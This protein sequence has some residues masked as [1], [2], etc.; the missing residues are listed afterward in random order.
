MDLELVPDNIR[1]LVDNRRL[2]DVVKLAMDLD[3]FSKIPDEMSLDELSLALDLDTQFVEYLMRVLCSSGFAEAIP[4]AGG[5]IVYRCTPVSSQ[6]LRQGSPLFIGQCVLESIETGKL[7]GG[8]VRN[9]PVTPSIDKTHWT[10]ER[11]RNIAGVA[12]LGGLQSAIASV[13]LAGHSRLLDI[14]GGHG[15]FSVFFTRKYPGL[16][17]TIV[18]LPE[19]AAIARDYVAHCEAG[20]SV[21]IVAADYRDLRPAGAYDVVFLSNVAASLPEIG[22]LLSIAKDSLEPGG[23]VVM[24]NFVSDAPDGPWSAITLLER[25]T[26]RGLKGLSTPELSGAMESNGFGEITTAGYNDCTVILTGIKR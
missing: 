4:A 25:Y 20:D 5:T 23:M 6:F 9:G 10:E 19:V 17:A 15:L 22:R 14:G 26:R 2:L 16:H 3:L 24:R 13:D 1:L 11:M 18:E 12:L 8:Y 21:D 7:L